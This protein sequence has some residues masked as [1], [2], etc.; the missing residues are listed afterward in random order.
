MG[1]D[2]IGVTTLVGFYGCP[3]KCRYCINKGCSYGTTTRADY[4]PE[5]L[6]SLL[7]IDAPYFRMTS[8]G[9]TFGGG[10]PLMQADY[11]HNVCELMP[12]EWHKTVETSLNVKW[13]LVEAVLHDI[14]FWY[15]DIKEVDAEIYKKY[16][17]RSNLRVLRNLK[18]LINSVGVDKVCVRYPIIPGYNSEEK[19]KEGI[20][21]IR[22][23]IS[24][25]TQFDEFEYIKC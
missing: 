6:V 4:T 2:G 11:I 22:D 24:L 13:S 3:L 20:E 8:G 15:V 16:T 1:T 5:E 19:R 14:D 21:H 9:V 10:E 25:Y 7:S 17:G 12:S 18:K 23:T